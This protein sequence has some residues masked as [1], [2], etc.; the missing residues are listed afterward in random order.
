MKTLS[1]ETSKRLRLLLDNIETEYSYYQV[2]IDRWDC[3]DWPLTTEDIFTKNE[4]INRQKELSLIFI[5]K[6][7]T[8]WEAIEFLPE[9]IIWNR[10][11][12]MTK[13]RISYIEN[14]YDM[15]YPDFKWKTL[16][17]AIEKM[18]IYL[19]DNDLLWTKTK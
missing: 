14:Y 15:E 17:E 4:F 18:I 10:C 8:L 2:Y 9:R 11:L 13:N 12:E 3:P 16:L 19:L 5:C 1:L 7:L 6:T